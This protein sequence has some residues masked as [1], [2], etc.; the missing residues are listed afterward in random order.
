MIVLKRQTFLLLEVL[1]AFAFIV[2]SFFPLVYPHYYIYQQQ[3]HFIDKIKTDTAVNNLYGSILVKLHTNE[4]TIQQIEEGHIFPI[5]EQLMEGISKG[6]NNSL[7]GNYKF[8]VK[9]NKKNDQ[10]GLYKVNL[11]IDIHPRGNTKEKE[12]LTFKYK[13][14]LARHFSKA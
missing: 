1:I 7:V 12:T 4:I 9:K 8:K 11:L 3:R 13:I 6:K 14:F 2:T 5:D 10:Y